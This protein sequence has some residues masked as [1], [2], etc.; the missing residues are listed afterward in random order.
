MVPAIIPTG[1]LLHHGTNNASHPTGPEWLAFD[2]EMSYAVMASKIPGPT[3]LR[4]YRTT[5]SARILYFNG[6]S[7]AWG[8]GW[9]DTQHAV[10]AGKG[11]ANATQPAW[12]DD[13]GRA[14]GLCEWGAP[15]GVEGIVRMNGGL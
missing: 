6:M 10:M 12:W 4:T 5:R 2:P 1:T 9:L 13:Y 7:A 3:Y 8:P 15:R 11:L 14:Q